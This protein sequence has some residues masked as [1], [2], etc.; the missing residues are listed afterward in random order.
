MGFQSAMA[1]GRSKNSG[2]NVF[3]RQPDI[4]DQEFSPEY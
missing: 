3:S 1:G 4:P 2:K